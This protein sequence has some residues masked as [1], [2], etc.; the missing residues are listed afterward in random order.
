MRRLAAHIVFLII[1]TALQGQTAHYR[2][3][4]FGSKDGLQ[5]KV[6]YNTAQDKKGYMWFGTATGLYRYDGHHF[7]YYRSPLDKAGSNISNILQAVLCDDDGNLW[8]GSLTTLQWYNPEKNVFWQPDMTKAVN[9]QAAGSYFYNF[10]RGKYTWCSTARNYVYRFSSED[11]SFLPLAPNYPAGASTTSLNTVEA[12]NYLYDIH[13][14]GIYQFKLDGSYVRTIPHPS[15]DISNGFRIEE[16]QAIYLPT[17]TSGMLKFE[18]PSGRITNAFPSAAALRNNYLY[19][20]AKDEAGNYYTG[21]TSLYIFNPGDGQVLDFY[22]NNAKNEYAFGAS[23]IVQIFTDREKNKWFCSHNG[24]SMLPWQNNQVKTVL[25]RDEATG[26]TTEAIGAYEEPSSGD[27]LLT[28]TSSRGLQVISRATGNVSTIMNHAEPDLYKK[29]ITGLIVAPDQQV[30]ASDDKHFFRYQHRDASLVP[31]E[32]KDQDGNPVRNIT[33]NVPDKNGKIFIG[34]GNY[35][36]YIWHY[37]AGPLVHY[38]KWEVIRTDSAAKD[39]III[40]C[41]AD[42]RQNIWFTGSN[43]IYEYRQSENKYYHHTPPENSGLPAIGESQYIAEDRNGHIWVA[44]TNNGLYEMYAEQGK[45][46]WKNYTANSGI[47]LPADY[48]RKIKLNPADGMLWIN[49]TA[50]LLKFDPERRKVI[51][52]LNMQNGLFAEGHGYS[53]NIFPGNRMVQL[54]YGAANIIDLGSY[55]TNRFRPL[56]QL[57]SVKIMTAEQLFSPGAEKKQLVVGYNQNFIQFEFSA[58]VFNNASQ[59]QYSYMLEHADRDWI[60]SGQGNTASYSGLKPGTYTFR[61]KAANNDGLWGDETVFT[62]R[63]RPPFYQRWWFILAC[64]LILGSIVFAWNRIRISQVKKEE[65]LKAAFQQQIAE[66]EMK[67][68]RAQMNPHFIFNSLNSIQKYILKNEHFEASQYLTKF[69]RLIRLIL[70]HSNQN[71]V[72][73][74]SELEMLKLY[75]EM[76]SLRF[77]NQFDYEIITGNNLQPDTV[78]IPSMLIQP[79]VEN[80][81][82][83]GLLHKESK[84][85]LTL[86]FSRDTRNN[87]L[88]IVED[89]GIGREKAVLLRSKQ[90]LKRKSYG[91]QITEDRIAII[92]RVQNMHATADVEDLFDANGNAAGTRVVLQI[93]LKPLTP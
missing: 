28:N 27:I 75:I 37:P 7:K 90:V 85:K 38:N 26:F 52:L 24:L 67:A 2:F 74:S 16:D 23:K 14:E 31:F 4:N 70:D 19:S 88:V 93:P 78:E 1:T 15:G 29:R 73:L 42:S 82:W 34:A 58:L 46:V 69:S 36:F 45:T 72:Q 59:N 81:I 41:I 8:L 83:H 33:R 64:S 10:S 92:N 40:P 63:I 3:I 86:S 6:V 13:P 87:L 49:N 84:G 56:V 89:N 11:S 77:D 48:F 17:Y 9:R 62:I 12:G 25:L 79:Y 55:R 57:N 43:G 47:G 5:D 60:Y 32:L 91:M 44:T 61:V 22:T 50:G 21:A 65:T 53:F 66:T 18:I 39:N 80:A 30:Y 76:E 51:S 71:T 35:G 68:L 20:I 54:Y